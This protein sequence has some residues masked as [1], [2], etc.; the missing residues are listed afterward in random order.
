MIYF[1]ETTNE[2]IELL[3]EP[4]YLSHCFKE[5]QGVGMEISEAAEYISE[6]FI[7]IIKKEYGDDWPK[8]YMRMY[9]ELIEK[10]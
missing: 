7:N 5:T 6:K 9:I 4:N 8:H 10:P 1:P 3:K 2:L